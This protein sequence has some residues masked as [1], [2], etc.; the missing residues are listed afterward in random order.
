MLAGSYMVVARIHS[1]IG[2]VAL[3][4]VIISQGLGYGLIFTLNYFFRFI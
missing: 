3:L 1:E 4:A 2:V